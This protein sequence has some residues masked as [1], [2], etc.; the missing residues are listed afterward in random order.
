MPDP[1]SYARVEFRPSGPLGQQLTAR[2]DI[3]TDG[4]TNRA[5]TEVARRDLTR[6]YALLAADL[7]AVH[8]T[9]GEALFLCDMLNGSHIDDQLLTVR[10]LHHEITDAIPDGLD[11]KWDVDGEK[12]A[13][14]VAGWTLSQRLAV[15]DA[16]E[17]YWQLDDDADD[18]N[19]ALQHVG[20]LRAATPP[21]IHPAQ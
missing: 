4:K 20:L 1:N 3:P 21:A 5:V 17:R 18:Y 6:L 19:Q 14:K 9:R 8:L 11:V 16:V 15:V 12:L 10:H 13:A 7:A 2:A